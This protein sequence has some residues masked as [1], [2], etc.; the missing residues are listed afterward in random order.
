[1]VFPFISVFNVS[2]KN[3][4]INQNFFNTRIII[5]FYQRIWRNSF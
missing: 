3:K 1:L 4:S 5:N 2:V